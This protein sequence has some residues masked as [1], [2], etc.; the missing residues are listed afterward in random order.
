MSYGT[1]VRDVTV[2]YV[3]GVKGTADWEVLGIAGWRAI[4]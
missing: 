4:A 3:W 2:T 1:D